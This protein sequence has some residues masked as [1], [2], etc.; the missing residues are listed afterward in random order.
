VYY[1]E[2]PIIWPLKISE[3]LNILQLIK[4]SYHRYKSFELLI[5]IFHNLIILSIMYYVSFLIC[6]WWVIILTKS[7]FNGIW[8]VEDCRHLKM[9]RVF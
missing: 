8:A 7:L 4:F 6:T 5:V 1:L 3:L 2:R 9:S